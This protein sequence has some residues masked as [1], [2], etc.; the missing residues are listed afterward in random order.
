MSERSC[1]QFSG[2]EK[3]LADSVSAAGEC[4]DNDFFLW[5]FAHIWCVYRGVHMCVFDRCVTGTMFLCSW[6]Q[7]GEFNRKNVLC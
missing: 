3:R 2:R 6:S 7:G 4:D 5:L 1:L